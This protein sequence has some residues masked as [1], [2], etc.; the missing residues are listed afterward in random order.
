VTG[1]GS[2]RR[3]V[4]KSKPDGPIVEVFRWQPVNRTERPP[5]FDRH[6]LAL[7]VAVFDQTPAERGHQMRGIL[8]RPDEMARAADFP[9]TN[10]HLSGQNKTGRDGRQHI[11][12]AVLSTTAV[13]W[14]CLRA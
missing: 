11:S 12:S 8:G 2:P 6:V 4:E 14:G 9:N 5:V 10:Q 1:S 13:C 7:D 3:N